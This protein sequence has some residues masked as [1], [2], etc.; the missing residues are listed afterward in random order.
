VTI[1]WTL[2]NM[3]YLAW[4]FIRQRDERAVERELQGFLERA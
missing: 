4:Y 1:V 2:A 3:L